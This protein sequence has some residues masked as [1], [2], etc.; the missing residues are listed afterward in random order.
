VSDLEYKIHPLVPLAK[1]SL[2]LRVP[3]SDLLLMLT[4]GLI[5]G[6]ER[7]LELLPAGSASGKKK[8]EPSES[9]EKSWFIWASEFD[10]LLNERLST[11][12]QRISINGL[13]H[14]FETREMPESQELIPPAA[15]EAI[16]S[17]SLGA[18]ESTFTVAIIEEENVAAYFEDKVFTEAVGNALGKELMARFHT[19]VQKNEQLS[20]R[21]ELLEKE[22]AGLKTE[23][24]LTIDPQP[25]I[26]QRLKSYFRYWFVASP[27][28]N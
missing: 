12:E 24:Y 25:S 7:V 6:E 10:R 5:K 23:L 22:V 9:T 13:E 28:S 4:E 16:D 11:L 3:E 26:W 14:I 8:K 15:P 2:L 1:A 21:L 27:R 20:L 17:V 19:E 18:G